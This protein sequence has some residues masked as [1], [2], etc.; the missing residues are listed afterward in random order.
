M[1][2]VDRRER[3]EPGRAS[4]EMSMMPGGRPSSTPGA[5]QPHPPEHV[6]TTNEAARISRDQTGRRRD[7]MNRRASAPELPCLN[8]SR[9]RVS[10]LGWGLGSS[11][12]ANAFRRASLRAELD[13]LVADDGGQFQLATERARRVAASIPFVT[14]AHPVGFEPTTLGFEVRCSIQ[15]S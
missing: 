3:R 4:C 12:A 2:A 11:E 1:P 10:A 6:W 15:L 7:Q 13:A 8:P 14:S 9:V 5:G